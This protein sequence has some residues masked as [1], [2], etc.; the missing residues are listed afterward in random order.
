MKK[1]ITQK[2]DKLWGYEL[3]LYSPVKS[4]ET[5]FEDGTKATVGPLVKIICANLPLSVQVH[6]DDK[7]AKEL[8]NQDNGKSEAWYVLDHKPNASLV[9]GLHTYDKEEIRAA[10]ANKSF[11]N[12]LKEVKV[13]TG[14]F[15]DIPAGLVHG[16]GAGITVLEVQQPSDTTYRYYDYDRLENGK[17]R[18]LHIDKA[19]KVQKEL[20]FA[21]QPSNHNPLTFINEVGSQTYMSEPSILEFDAIIV[22]LENY[23]T[24]LANKGEKISFNKYCII[25]IK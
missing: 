18:E 3:W 25:S 24:F 13:K 5:L 4:K 2:Y 15:Y 7:F 10:I 1:V 9:L 11:K 14:D 23:D 22:D 17:A 12:L 21:L 19:L 16:I 6:P 20:P 8:E